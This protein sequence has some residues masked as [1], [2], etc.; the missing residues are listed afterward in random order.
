MR[1]SPTKRNN[2][3]NPNVDTV[4]TVYM[5]IGKNSFSPFMIRLKL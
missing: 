5:L 4:I 2:P 1:S 3:G